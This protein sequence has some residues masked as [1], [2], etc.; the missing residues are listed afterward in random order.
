MAFA[1]GGKVLATAAW[2]LVKLWD[3]KTGKVAAT[4]RRDTGYPVAFSS[5]LALAAVHDALDAVHE[6]DIKLWDVATGKDRSTLQ[7]H[8]ADDLLGVVLFS[9]DGKTLASVGVSLRLSGGVPGL[10]VQLE[11]VGQLKLW[12]VRTGKELAALKGH[13]DGVHCVAYSL[14]GRMLATATKDKSIRLWE[15]NPEK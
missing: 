5:D 10:G 2:G 6:E 11:S 3:L 9:P 15:M 1:P 4:Y 8:A 13:K 7:G 12:D 14:D